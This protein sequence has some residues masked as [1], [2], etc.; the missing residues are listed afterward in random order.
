MRKRIIK[1]KKLPVICMVV[2]G[3]VA[4]AALF[5]AV[6]SDAAEEKAIANKTWDEVEKVIK[7]KLG[8]GYEEVGLCTGFLY[9]CLDNA[10]GVDWGTNSTVAQLEKKMINAGVT[11]VAEGKNG[12]SEAGMKPGDIVIF[13]DG[14]TR[15]HCAILGDEGRLYHATSSGVN[16]S[17]TLERWMKLPDSAKN[18]DKYIVY[19]GLISLGNI[20]LIKSSSEQEITEGNGCY[21]LKGAEYGLY[22]GEVL[23]GV[24]TTDDEGRAV[25]TDIPYGA[26]TLKEIKPSK[27]YALDRSQYSIVVDRKSVSIDVKEEPQSNKV[28]ALL[29]KVDNEIHEAWREENRGQAGASLEGALYSVKYY[30]GYYD[31]AADLRGEEHVRSW[32]IRTDESGQ[33]AL[34]EESVVSGDEL[35]RSSDGDV[36][37]PLGTVIIS[38]M[39][40]PKGYMTDSSRHVVQITSDGTEKFVDTYVTPVHRE[41]IIRGD[42]ELIK[43]EDGT[44]KRLGGIP[45]TITS[46]TTGESHTIVTDIN[47]YASTSSAWNPHTGDTNGGTETSGIWFGNIDVVTDAGGALPYDTYIID[48]QSCEANE[49]LALIQGVEIRIHKNGAVVSL[50]TVTNDRQTPDDSEKPEPKTPDEP[51][52]YE[53]DEPESQ[54]PKT[55]EP[56]VPQKPEITVQ[57]QGGPE[58]GD[59][60]PKKIIAAFNIMVIA[61]AAGCALALRRKKT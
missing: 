25:M 24:L 7:T 1:A 27:G 38:E 13:L 41:Q 53:P 60:L 48:E 12:G 21:S 49:G 5:G 9:W 58:T 4:G 51:P 34:S 32:V 26:Y 18:C 16:E 46:K 31:E 19:R 36:I 8:E 23:Q 57:E 52:G 61:A 40:A 30:D 22:K 55:P 39:A 56:D 10:Y 28:R 42:I 35:Y 14:S 15:T 6:K 17:Y 11:K 3:M 44:M 20:I 43:T 50:G 37:L 54:K 29:Y 45:F 59:M 47:G 2:A 33:A